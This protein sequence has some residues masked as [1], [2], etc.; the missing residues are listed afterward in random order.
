MNNMSMTTTAVADPAS[1]AARCDDPSSVR[2]GILCVL[3]VAVCAMAIYPVVDGPWSDDFSYIK[4]A[5]DFERTGKVLYNGWATAML[6]WLIPWG[7]LFIKL[8]GF[9]FTI[10]RVSLFP[11]AAATIYLLHQILRRFGIDP[12]NAVFGT[13]AIGLS[14]L[15][16]LM[17]TNY[18]T[19][20][21]GLLV[22]LVCIYMCQ[23]AVAARTDN[24]ALLWLISAALVNVAGGTVRQI[25][26]LGALVMVPSTAWLLRERRG[27][28]VTGVLMWLLSLGAIVA[29]VHWFNKQPYS[30][31]EPILPW[32]IGLKGLFHLAEQVIMTLLC[33]LLIVLPVSMAWMTTARRLNKSAKWRFAIV[34][35]SL[36]LLG[37]YLYM[38]GV[39][40]R[41]A[42]PWLVQLLA[43]TVFGRAWLW[44]RA[45][46]SLL[47]IAPAVLLIEQFVSK[48][49]SMSSD[50]GQP[51]SWTQLRWILGPFALSYLILLL[52][53]ATWQAIQDRYLLGVAPIAIILLLKLYQEHI[54]PTLPVG[55][56]IVLIVVAVIAIGDVHDSFAASRALT[57]AV[58]IV[59]KS[60][61]PKKSLA[62]GWARDGWVQVGDG[63]HINDPR[64]KV[65]IGAY[66]PY[67]PDLRLPPECLSWF[68]SYTPAITPTYVIVSTPKSC[69]APTS[70][71]VIHYRTWFPPFRRIIYVEKLA[72]S[73][74]P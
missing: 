69:F 29:C 32:P 63:G 39:N 51:S 45:I 17:A 34:M 26:W 25:A 30:V 8:F 7:A 10:L 22:I 42:E 13:L 36:S 12:Q 21:P 6:G 49:W 43:T 46:I 18:M 66:R 4:T 41:W 72:T 68:A 54:K 57:N 28:K 62:A 61:V 14:P 74:T 2:N 23:R 9:S 55:S 27:T 56:F 15:F 59:E 5:L 1:A 44:V 50:A 37:V 64:I 47:A 71:P 40:D 3:L 67:T 38:T 60:G 48:G 20:V 33:L 16:L 19:D 65:P 11:I 73:S 58:T 53:R 35:V 24:R 70:F 31:P 52:P